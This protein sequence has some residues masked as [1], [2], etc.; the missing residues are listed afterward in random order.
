MALTEKCL[1]SAINRVLKTISGNEKYKHLYPQ[2]EEILE[3]PIEMTFSKAGNSSI[4]NGISCLLELLYNQKQISNR[5]W[6]FYFIIIELYVNDRGLIDEYIV[7]AMV[8]LM[9]YIQKTPQ[10]FRHGVFDGFGSC[11]D[12]MFNFIGKI[13]LDAR[14]NNDKVKA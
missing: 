3:L 13:F 12:M 9:N 2:L 14:E 11:M 1:T 10:D 8:P 5:M 4:V 6:K 7:H